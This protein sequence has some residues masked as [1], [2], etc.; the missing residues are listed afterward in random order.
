[1]TQSYESTYLSLRYTY[2]HQNNYKLAYH[3]ISHSCEGAFIRIF[4]GVL[5]CPPSKITWHGE[6]SS[7]TTLSTLSLIDWIVTVRISHF[8]FYQTY[9]VIPNSNRRQGMPKVGYQTDSTGCFRT[10]H[11]RQVIFWY[12]L[13]MRT[14]H[15]TYKCVN[16]FTFWFCHFDMKYQCR[17]N[18]DS[19]NEI[20]IQ[21]LVR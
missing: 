13:L 8:W 16:T 19:K 20:C 6:T 3:K 1:M 15:H 9:T 2:M 4:V 11:V 10:F 21:R 7:T 17:I 14:P 18:S 5:A 12:Y